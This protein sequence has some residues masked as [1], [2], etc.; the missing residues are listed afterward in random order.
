MK[1]L[2]I[3]NAICLFALALLCHVQ[4]A[5]A[6][7]TASCLTSPTTIDCDEPTVNAGTAALITPTFPNPIPACEKVTNSCSFNFSVPA[8][9]QTEWSSFL[10]SAFVNTAGSC[11]A[12]GGCVEPV[13]GVCGGSNGQ[14]WSHCSGGVCAPGH[15]CGPGYTMGCAA[16]SVINSGYYISGGY[17]TFYWTCSGS[18]GGAITFIGFKKPTRCAPPTP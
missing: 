18:N 17:F 9:T 12:V 14:V 1:K 10:Q 4:D 16:G 11:A 15:V 5:A 7:N 6:Q 2:L 3:N 13:N 8:A